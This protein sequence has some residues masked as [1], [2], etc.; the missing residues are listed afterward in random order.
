MMVVVGDGLSTVTTAADVTCSLGGRSVP[1]IVTAAAVPHTDVT[2]TMGVKE[3][4]ATV[5]DAVDPSAGL[6]PDDTTVTLSLDSP[7][8]EAGEPMGVLGFAC[9]SDAVGTDL[10]Y[11]LAG[12]D[13]AAFSLSSAT[14]TV[15]T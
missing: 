10:V 3:Y 6:T 7:M 13:A 14:C 8:T 1:I 2:V 9:A 5:D 12:T 4:D 11:T 15:T